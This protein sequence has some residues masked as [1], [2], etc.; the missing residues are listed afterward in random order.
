MVI[1]TMLSPWKSEILPL[2]YERVMWERFPQIGIESNRS[3]AACHLSPQ[4]RDATACAN[5][6]KAL[7]IA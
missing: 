7:S 3:V 1:E 4:H 2:D 6:S 5:S